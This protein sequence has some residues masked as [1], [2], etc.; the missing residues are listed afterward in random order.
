M[1]SANFGRFEIVS[2]GQFNTA[3]ATPGM[4]RHTVK[5]ALY[6]GGLFFVWGITLTLAGLRLGVIAL[7]YSLRESNNASG[8]VALLHVSEG[9]VNLV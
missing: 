4:V 5:I 7:A 2:K 8:H 6:E 1:G 3:D 9:V